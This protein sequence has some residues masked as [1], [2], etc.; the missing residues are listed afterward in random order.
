MLKLIGTSM[1]S[2][3]TYLFATSKLQP[4]FEYAHLDI[5]NVMKIYQMPIL[6]Q[7]FVKLSLKLQP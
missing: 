1:Y 3:W 2:Q 4:D 5:W 7:Y 6:P